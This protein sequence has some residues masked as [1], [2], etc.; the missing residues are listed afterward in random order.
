MPIY[1]KALVRDV[2]P[3][4]CK[5][6]ENQPPCLPVANKTIW[7][8]S[9]MRNYTDEKFMA[10]WTIPLPSLHRIKLNF[11]VANF[12]NQDRIYTDYER[13]G[14][15]E[16]SQIDTAHLYTEFE[17][18]NLQNKSSAISVVLLHHSQELP[19]FSFTYNIIPEHCTNCSM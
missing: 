6:I 7:G 8:I 16:H 4:L 12:T 5:K 9:D 15:R 17:V 3:S 2:L 18:Q 14:K 11:Q 1:E 19:F 13:N 10:I